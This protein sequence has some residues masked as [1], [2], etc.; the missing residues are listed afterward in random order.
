M[1]WNATMKLKLKIQE[2]L[3]KNSLFPTLGIQIKGLV[4]NSWKVTKY[5]KKHLKKAEEYSSRNSV[6]IRTKIS[7]AV[8]N[9]LRMIAKKLV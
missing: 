5:D 2:R 8:L 1:D 3:N 9:M 6:S 7:I 4:L